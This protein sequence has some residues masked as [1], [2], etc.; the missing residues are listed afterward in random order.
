MV[1]ECAAM[2][3]LYELLEALPDDDADG[4]KF[5]RERFQAGGVRPLACLFARILKKKR[6][7]WDRHGNDFRSNALS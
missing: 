1:F 6:S 5:W 2:K 7:T 3:T 4:Q